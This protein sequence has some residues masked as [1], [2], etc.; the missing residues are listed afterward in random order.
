MLISSY[1]D[2]SVVIAFRAN[3]NRHKSKLILQVYLPHASQWTNATL[4]F[5]EFI[6]FHEI[7][8]KKHPVQLKK[9]WP[10][11]DKDYSLHYINTCLLALNTLN[12]REWMDI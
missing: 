9:L 11:Y 5:T 1:G 7:T 4:W 12:K 6:S 3:Y 8:K 10:F 2:K